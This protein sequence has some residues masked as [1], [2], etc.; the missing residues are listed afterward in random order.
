MS[1]TSHADPVLLAAKAVDEAL[2]AQRIDVLGQIGAYSATGVNRQALTPEDAD[3]QLQVIAWGRDIGMQPST[4]AI[5]NLYLRLEGSDASLPPVMVGSHLDTQPTGG[6]YDGAYGV[7]AG[8]EVARAIVASGLRPTRSI[9]VVAWMNE[10]GSRFAPGMSGSAVYG[11]ART[12]ESTLAVTDGQGVTIAQALADVQQRLGPLPQ[13]ALQG[14]LHAY[15]EPHVEQGI[16]LERKGLSIGVLT[17]MQGKQTFK[18]TVHGEAAHA[19]TSLRVQRKDALLGAMRC[20]QR[21]TEVYHD[22]EDVV[23]FT[24]GRLVVEPNAPS[25]VASQVTMSV[26]LRHP[27]NDTLESLGQQVQTL[28]N[29]VCAPCTVAV[30]CLSK[31]SSDLFD[32]GIQQVLRDSCSQLGIACMDMASSAGHD[33]RYLIDLC[34]TG[35]FFIPSRDGATHNDQEYTSPFDM[36]EGARVLTAAV[37]KLAL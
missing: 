23:R 10:E 9:D 7:L 3:G 2:L 37:V 13:R 11:G 27:D 29:E 8:L 31:A 25:V 33:S 21:M 22:E 35:M 30:E 12:L 24:V 17:S 4:D 15:I 14:P 18:V 26:D 1:D 32:S 19:G 6:R 5:G 34:P 16:V 20:I 28:C 36:A